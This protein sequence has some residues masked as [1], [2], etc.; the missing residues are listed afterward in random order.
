MADNLPDPATAEDSEAL[1]QTTEDSEVLKPEETSLGEESDGGTDSTESEEDDAGAVIV[2]IDGEQLTRAD[3]QEMKKN[4]MFHEDYTKKRMSETAAHKTAMAEVQQQANE[5]TAHLK[6]VED[7]VAEEEAKIDWDELR[8]VDT[9]EYLKQ[10]EIFDARKKKIADAKKQAGD[11]SSSGE[12]QRISD[13]TEKLL[14][15]KP[16]WLDAQGDVTDI[17]KDDMKLIGSYQKAIGWTKKEIQAPMDHKHSLAL[18]DA[19][20]Y[21]ALKGK[22]SAMKK[23]LKKAPVVTKPKQSSKGSV[24]KSAAEMMF[25][26]S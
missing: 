3:L 8:D 6:A 25:D 4:Q 18:L 9:S 17:Y 13:E 2:D 26:K 14:T 24:K 21:H 23:E 19:A 11:F 5:L 15:A 7:M 10:K 1:N 16:E 12:D 22:K 20:R